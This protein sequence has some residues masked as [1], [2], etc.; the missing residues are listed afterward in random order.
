MQVSNYVHPHHSR[1]IAEASYKG[2]KHIYTVQT[3]N[4]ILIAN[5]L[6]NSTNKGC[7]SFAFGPAPCFSFLPLKNQDSLT[8]QLPH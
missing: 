4:D 7:M 2:C 8:E 3:F 6:V 5:I 1:I